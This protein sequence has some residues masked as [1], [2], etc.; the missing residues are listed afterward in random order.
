MKSCIQLCW[1]APRNAAGPLSGP[2]Y[3]RPADLHRLDAVTAAADRCEAG[4]ANAA[5]TTTS[6]ATD[7][8]IASATTFLSN[9]C[10][11]LWGC[12]RSDDAGT[13]RLAPWGEATDSTLELPG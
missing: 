2:A 11:L 7:A 1:S 9:N 6:D 3:A 5:A 10:F 13:R 8:A 4:R 12:L